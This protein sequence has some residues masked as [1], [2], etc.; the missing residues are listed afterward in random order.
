MAETEHDD[1][2]MSQG[3]IKKILG[4][5]N[6]PNISLPET[7]NPMSV[8]V[9]QRLKIVLPKNINVSSPVDNKNHLDFKTMCDQMDA[10]YDKLVTV[11][12]SSDIVD[13]MPPAYWLEALEVYE[14]NPPSSLHVSYFI[15]AAIEIYL[16]E[17]FASLPN[18]KDSQNEME[19]T[20]LSAQISFDMGKRSHLSTDYN[21]LSKLFLSIIKKFAPAMRGELKRQQGKA[22]QPD[23]TMEEYSGW[24]ADIDERIKKGSRQSPLQRAGR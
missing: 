17:R 12:G 9:Y 6:S 15:L 19:E 13:E 21:S 4:S 2:P 1:K 20:L 11:F 5:I 16:F 7:L 10:G 24:L 8:H 22:R 18:P 14:S 3:E 23:K